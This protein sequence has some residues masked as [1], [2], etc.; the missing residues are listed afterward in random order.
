VLNNSQKNIVSKL[1]M[2]KEISSSIEFQLSTFNDTSSSES[3]SI[4]I[5]VAVEI[6]KFLFSKRNF[7]QKM[8]N[9]SRKNQ[10]LN[11][12]NNIF[13]RKK[14]SLYSNSLKLSKK[15]SEI[16]NASLNVLTSKNINSRINVVN[17]V[18]KKRVRKFSKDFANTT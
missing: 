6:S 3:T 15:F 14:C 1:M 2:K 8:I 9:L 5:F 12:E 16:E 7:K 13:F 10:L 17:I 4:N 18:R 11:K